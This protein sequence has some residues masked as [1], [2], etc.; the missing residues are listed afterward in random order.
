MNAML[1][2]AGTALLFIA[3]A[4]A[5]AAQ[6]AAPATDPASIIDAALAEE[7]SEPKLR[8]FERVER[9]VSAGRAGLPIL[10]ERL[11]E[12]NVDPST[13]AIHCH[14]SEAISLL[15]LPTDDE[16]IDALLAF[17]TDD[18][19]LLVEC[20]PLLRIGGRAAREALDRLEKSN[21]S[22]EELGV[23][24]DVL[25]TLRE[26]T[27][28]E[29]A[30][31]A[32]TRLARRPGPRYVQVQAEVECVPRLR[33]ALDFRRHPDASETRRQLLA[34]V[35]KEHPDFILIT[36]GLAEY[37]ALDRLVELQARETVPE[38]VRIRAT[39]PSNPHQLVR[40]IVALGGSVPESDA[41]FKLPDGT[42]Y[43]PTFALMR[44]DVNADDYLRFA[45]RLPID[46]RR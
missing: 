23:V 6:E 28:L 43:G 42:P 44:L 17:V 14:L 18:R 24:V 39:W 22:P 2:A 11:R 31:G 29:Y 40:A 5:L 38:L 46:R 25:W 20:R 37:W 10:V 33:I 8:T 32:L 12:R 35:R 27:D 41:Q 45:A 26:P 3:L 1:H 19:S 36:G 16:A 30:I 34:M 9:L 7:P 15:A 4:S 13:D 21:L